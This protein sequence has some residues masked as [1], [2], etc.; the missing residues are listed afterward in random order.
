MK[1]T[2]KALQD[3]YV[4]KGGQL[5][6]VADITTIPDMID[7]I[8][9][10]GGGGSSLPAVTSDD[11][12]KLLTVVEGAW[13]KATPSGGAST[14]VFNATFGSF[15]TGSKINLSDSKTVKD[16]RDAIATG[17]IVVIRGVSQGYAYYLS[18]NE[19]CIYG[20][21]YASGNFI[22]AIATLTGLA[23]SATQIAFTKSVVL[24]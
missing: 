21:N 1:T 12:G 20:M 17:A 4:E 22:T 3:Y 23:D 13:D 15:D 24:T 2:V 7:A 8:T 14:V 16:I 5:A 6:D 11:N 9:A 18:V 19:T 10:L